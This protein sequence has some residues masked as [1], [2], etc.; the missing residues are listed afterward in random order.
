MNYCK[1]SNKDSQKG[2]IKQSNGYSVNHLSHKHFHKWHVWLPFLCEEGGACF[3][4][5]VHCPA[6]YNS[7]F[8]IS[9]RAMQ[10]W[11]LKLTNQN[12]MFRQSRLVD[13]N[14]QV[15]ECWKLA[16]YE[17]DWLISKFN[18]ILGQLTSN[19]WYCHHQ[20]GSHTLPVC[21]VVWEPNYTLWMLVIT[22]HV[23]AINSVPSHTLQI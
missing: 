15:K 2:I 21:M 7:K 1:S 17:F 8:H 19:S 12:H 9:C 11:F 10:Y 20:F 13:S 5:L 6:F 22:L 16:F 3:M 4:W 23:N 14:Q 18:N